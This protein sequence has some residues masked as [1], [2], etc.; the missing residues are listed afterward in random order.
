MADLKHRIPIN[1]PLERVYQA[2]TTAEGLSGWWT[3][4]VEAEQR[5]GETV[6]LGFY[7]RA[8][9]YRMRID[10]LEPERR[11]LWTCE[12]GQEWEGTKLRFELDPADDGTILNFTHANW[13]ATTP[14]FYECNS[15]WGELMY[16]LKAYA[17]NNEP[18][19]HFTKACRV[20]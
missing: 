7:N 5:E 18:G 2:V 13:R 10:V 8:T 15:T 11:V 12:T 16:R 17:E 14:F 4:D 6:Q 19:P 20:Y 1:A 3:E 9:V